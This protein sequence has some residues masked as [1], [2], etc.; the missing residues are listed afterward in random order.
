MFHY[1]NFS[2]FLTHFCGSKNRS[3]GSTDGS[4]ANMGTLT[5]VMI[6]QR[7]KLKKSITMYE[8]ISSVFISTAGGLRVITINKKQFQAKLKLRH[9][10][11]TEICLK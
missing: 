10:N 3:V 2:G 11:E 5:D 6:N 1:V 8:Y 4:Y 9:C 7:K